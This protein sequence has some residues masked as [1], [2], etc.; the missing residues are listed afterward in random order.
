MKTYYRFLVLVWKVENDLKCVDVKIYIRFEN[1]KNVEIRKRVSENVYLSINPHYKQ[2]R[3]RQQLSS[4]NG[5]NYWKKFSV[6]SENMHI[7]Q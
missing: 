7:F 3:Y 6:I 5:E 1:I 4:E 2:L